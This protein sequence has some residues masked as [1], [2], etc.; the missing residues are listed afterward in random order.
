MYASSHTSVGLT[1]CIFIVFFSFEYFDWF[2]HY[3]ACRVTLTLTAHN[4]PPIL[5]GLALELALVIWFW[6]QF[7]LNMYVLITPTNGQS[8]NCTISEA[9]LWVWS[10]GHYGLYGNCTMSIYRWIYVILQN[11]PINSINH[12]ENCFMTYGF[13]HFHYRN[14]SLCQSIGLPI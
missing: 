11:T 5:T 7:W 14:M 1:S 12:L 13:E 3:A 8:I 10:L 9:Q 6:C 4:H 2:D